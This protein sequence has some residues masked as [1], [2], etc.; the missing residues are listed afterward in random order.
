MK[1][2]LR[3]DYYVYAYLRQ[4]DS[5]RAAAETPYYIGKGHG[6]RINEKYG[7]PPLPKKER[8][9]KVAENLTEEAALDLEIK[10]IEKYGRVKYDEGG[11][12]Y[13]MSLG[14]EGHS[15]YKTEE[16]R[17]TVRRAYFESD[18]WK[19]V[20]KRSYEKRVERMK[21]DTEEGRMMREKKAEVDKRHRQNPKH[22][23]KILAKQKEWYENNKEEI[24][25]KQREKRATPEGRAKARSIDKK[26]YYKR[27]QDPVKKETELKYKREWF[28]RKL[29]QMSEEDEREFR[30]ERN[31]RARENYRKRKQ[32]KGL[33]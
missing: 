13:N 23:K 16:A 5:K 29:E 22:R 12:L 28:Q 20:Q 21:A 30:N 7:H 4:R 14:G 11:I 25:A 17:E 1:E 26:C 27:M 9:I 19:E 10:L 31:R 33:T 32:K 2:T 24:L 15:I 3:T 18:R 6:Y 8:R